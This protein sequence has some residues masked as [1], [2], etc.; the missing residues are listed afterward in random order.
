MVTLYLL[1]TPPSPI[2]KLESVNN[3]KLHIFNSRKII[4]IGRCSPICRKFKKVKSINGRFVMFS[5]VRR[6]ILRAEFADISKFCRRAPLPNN[7]E[8]WEKQKKYNRCIPLSRLPE[9]AST[10]LKKSEKIFF[11]KIMI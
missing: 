8:V 6:I 1:R 9:I 10:T 11:A 7:K 2:F 5:I 3:E 4:C